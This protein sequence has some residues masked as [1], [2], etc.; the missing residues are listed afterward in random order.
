MSYRIGS[1]TIE[2]G[3]ALS[4]IIDTIPD[5]V[6]LIESDG[7]I[8][9]FNRACER[10]FG[11]RAKEI[12][13]K[14]V[15]CLLPERH[16]E[17][18]EGYF[19]C[20]GD[21][22]AQ[23]IAQGR[24]TE[25]QRK[26]GTVFPIELS[27]GQVDDEGS[28]G[29][30][31][32]IRD[33]TDRKRTEQSLLEADSQHRAIIETA[34]DGVIIIDSL[35]TIRTYNPACES[36]FGFASEEVV[37]RNVKMLMPSPD[38]DRHD[39][40]L[41]RYRECGE[42]KI[43][44][45]GREVIGRRKDGS[46]FPLELSVGETDKGGSL[47]FVGIL[48]EITERKVI[49]EQVRDS[50]EA[51]QRQIDDLQFAQTCLEEQGHEM[52]V[53]AE[54]LAEAKDE[55]ESASKAKSDFLAAMSH[56]IR[57][58]MN[59][60]I[61]LSRLL[62]AADLGD[63]QSSQ[64]RMILDCAETLM[65][66][67]NDILDLSKIEAGHLE[68]DPG[69]FDVAELFRTVERLW[70]GKAS[71]KKL[72][73]RVRLQPKL[74]A[75]LVG[76]QMRLRQI[77]FNLISN[78]IKFTLEGHVELRVSL[79]ERGEDS[80]VLVI[81]VEDSGMGIDQAI[82]DKLF[83][84]FV[85]ADRSISRDFGGTGLGLAIC[86]NLVEMMQGRISLESEPGAGTTFRVEVRLQAAEEDQRVETEAGT[87]SGAPAPC[88]PGTGARILV[89]ED[90]PV[91]QA[92]MQ[93]LLKPTGHA[94]EI[95]GNGL[96]AL[97]ALTRA[98]FDLVLMDSQ[99]PEMDGVTATREIRAM[100]GP[101]SRVPIIALTANAMVGDRERY[102]EAGM[103]DYVPKPIEPDALFSAIARHLRQRAA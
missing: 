72:D 56:E 8:G 74:P 85:Q 49:E 57:T 100:E 82:Q 43:I 10:L 44:G 35:G 101:V 39:G 5:G 94:V 46:T 6:V 64:A 77:V 14:S 11:Y 51:L 88:A 9:L 59:G 93:A 13:G 76:D 41:R 19:R 18:H 65:G 25:G 36:M 75:R 89:V 27:V 95:A 91:N 81:E 96:E 12:I 1:L 52:A 24:E 71:E 92:L 30:V 17:Q 73:F 61:G 23:S 50:E 53:L 31:G 4:A 99:M 47:I 103:T 69:P 15:G 102:L 40:Y 87:R 3:A 78:A 37:G 45:T 79:G 86:R 98:D 38:F 34:V 80:V 55:A 16:R 58:P 83:Q 62:A 63:E 66:L 21:A 28:S 70:A 48:R 67:L 60:I 97:E 7:T 22:G 42:R 68:L 54:E 20:E 33:I 29:F 32:I 2:S 84:K 26:D 90:N